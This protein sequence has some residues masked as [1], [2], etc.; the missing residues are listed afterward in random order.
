MIERLKCLFPPHNS[1]MGLEMELTNDHVYVMKFYENAQHI[2]IKEL[3]WKHLCP[4]S[5]PHEVSNF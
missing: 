2:R 5:M 3:Y 4:E 1:E